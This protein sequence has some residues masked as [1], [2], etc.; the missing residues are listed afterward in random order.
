[1]RRLFRS[2][3]RRERGLA[4][5]VATG[6]LLVGSLPLMLVVWLLFHAAEQTLTAQVEHDISAVADQKMAQ[7]EGFARDRLRE[8]SALAYTPSIVQALQRYAAAYKVNRLDSADYLDAD[9]EY[10][11]L[12][13]R[14]ADSFGATTNWGP[15]CWTV[16][17]HIRI[18]PKSFSA[19]AP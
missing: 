19:A 18:S 8:A 1:M 17:R 12:L 10:R 4:V 7:I 13:T 11:H 6:A 9:K 5:E 14:Y 2:L 15:I 16:A 3:I